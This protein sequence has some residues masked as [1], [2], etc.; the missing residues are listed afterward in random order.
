MCASFGESLG[1][2]SRL[3][4]RDSKN[5][6]NMSVLFLMAFFS[7]SLLSFEEKANATQEIK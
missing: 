4:N 1:V 5:R 3:N 2:A 7:P 6:D